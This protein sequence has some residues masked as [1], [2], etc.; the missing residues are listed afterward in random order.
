M[1]VACS[2]VAFTREPLEQALRHI[3]VL[4][5]PKVDL[6]IAPD[7]PH[8]TAAQIVSD[9]ASVLGRI[10]QAPTIGFAALTLRFDTTGEAMFEQLDRVAHFAKQ[11]SAPVLVVEAAPV[12]AARDQE[13]ARL[14]EMERIASLHGTVLTLTTKTGTLTETPDGAVELCKAVPGLGLTLDPSHYTCG[15]HQGKSYDEV[16][17]YVRHAHLRDSG[18][19]MDQFQVR[20]G[21]GEIEYGRIVTSLKRFNYRGSLAVAIEDTIPSEMDYEAEVRKLLL[22]IESLI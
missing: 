14:T 18:R 4:E 3:A 5:F 13:V 10:R 8:L 17:P 1:D 7:S 19:T 15:P 16:F 11:L 20:V 2:T 6:A 21:R 9:P 22:L 12:G